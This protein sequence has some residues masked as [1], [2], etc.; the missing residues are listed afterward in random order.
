VAAVGEA[1]TR[2]AVG[3]QVVGV[4]EGCFA[5]YVS[6]KESMLVAQPPELTAVQAAAL[7]ISGLTALQAVR[8]QGEVQPGQQVLVVG[9]SGGVGSF[10]VQIAVA[11]GARVTG[12]CS[13]GKVDLVRSLGAAEVLD[14]TRDALPADHRYDVVVDT[15]G[16]RPLHQLRRALAPRGR[17]VIVGGETGGRWLGGVDRQLRALLLNP[18]LRQRLGSFLSSEGRDDLQ[19][20]A[21]LVGSGA[22]VPAVDRTWPLD[23]VPDAMRYLVAGRAAGKVVIEL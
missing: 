8:D 14:Y 7:P 6:A 19:A 16:N 15:G 20:L 11:A 23:G 21:D 4:A 13:T 17:L 22:V 12:V 1:V 5:E 3:D 18:F 10:A 9:A 2:F